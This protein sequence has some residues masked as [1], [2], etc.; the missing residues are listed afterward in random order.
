MPMIAPLSDQE[1][2][3]AVRSIFGVVQKQRGM[4]PNI[5]RT[6]GHAPE[7]LEAT[8]KFNQAIQKDLPPK[9]R[10]LAYLKTTILNHC[11]Y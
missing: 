2:P 9:L 6:M 5:F 3:E 4:V 1:A 11:D 7:V 8:L 10:E